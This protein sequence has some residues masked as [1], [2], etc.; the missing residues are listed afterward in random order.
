MDSWFCQGLEILKKN[1]SEILQQKNQCVKK[2][3][4]EFLTEVSM[5]QN[6]EYLRYNN[7]FRVSQNN[8]RKSEKLKIVFMI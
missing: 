1:Q 8:E 7:I 5:S 6:K 2:I 3:Q 4:C